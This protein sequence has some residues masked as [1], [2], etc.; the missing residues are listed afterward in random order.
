MTRVPCAEEQDRVQAARP[1]NQQGHMEQ[2]PDGCQGEPGTPWGREMGWEGCA[3]PHADNKTLSC[4]VETGNWGGFRGTWA[5]VTLARGA[6]AGPALAVQ[7]CLPQGYPWQGE[8]ALPLATAKASFVLQT[9]H[10]P[11]CQ[12][13]LKFLSQWCGGLPSTSFSF[14]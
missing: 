5:G 11:A 14:Q 2:V 10:S 1:R 8:M 3:T 9:S 7:L 12:D 13:V 6:G 4:G